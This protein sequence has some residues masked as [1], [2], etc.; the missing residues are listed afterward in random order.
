MVLPSSVRITN[1]NRLSRGEWES[2]N[3]RGRYSLRGPVVIIISIITSFVQISCKRIDAL[4]KSP[5]FWLIERKLEA[6]PVR[7]PSVS[8]LKVDQALSVCSSLLSSWTWLQRPKLISSPPPAV[9]SNWW[10][11]A[12]RTPLLTLFKS[13]CPT[14]IRDRS[15][16]FDFYFNSR[17]QPITLTAAHFVPRLS[18]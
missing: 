6:G 17:P 15:L 14:P 3:E 11:S 2:G 4:H 10:P 1:P 16:E 7:T 9:Q 8:I 18:P 13:H 5:L 12:T